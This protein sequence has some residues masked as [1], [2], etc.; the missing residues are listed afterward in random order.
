MNLLWCS[1]KV[2]SIPYSH[3]PTS[4]TYHNTFSYL[5]SFPILGTISWSPDINS[6]RWCCKTKESWTQPFFGHRSAPMRLPAKTNGPRTTDRINPQSSRFPQH[7]FDLLCAI[8]AINTW[9]KS[10]CV[11]SASW[12]IQHEMW[13][14]QQASSLGNALVKKTTKQ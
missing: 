8:L 5:H 12:R 1:R 3:N 7:L 10:I 2:C 6:K 13:I 11:W 4:S 14:R 9:L